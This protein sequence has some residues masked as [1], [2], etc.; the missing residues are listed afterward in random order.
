MKIARH[1]VEA[2]DRQKVGWRI[3]AEQMNRDGLKTRK[4][5]K[6]TID[7]LRNV[8]KRWSGKL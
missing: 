8:H 2:R 7:T 3:L 5:K 4:G 1:N 6:W